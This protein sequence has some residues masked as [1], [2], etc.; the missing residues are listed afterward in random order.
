MKIEGY[1]LKCKEKR[2]MVSPQ[3]EWAANG[4]PATRGTCPVCGTN[5]YKRGHTAAHD[6]LPKPEIQ[7]RPKKKT[8]TKKKASA[9][10]K[11]TATKKAA[12]KNETSVRRTGKLVIV[13]SPA[14]AKTI[15]RYLGKGYT[16]K[17]SV[18]HVRDLLKSR[19]SVDT[20]NEFT[21]EYRVPNDKRKLVKELAEAAAKAQEI[22]LATDPDREGEAIAWHVQES[23]EMDPERTKRVVFHEITKPAILAA[24]E[25]PREIDMDRVD[26]QQARRILDRLVGYKLSPL[27]WRKVH[28]RLSAGRVQSVAVRLVVERERE[29]DNFEPVEYWSLKAELSQQKYQDEA[30]RPFF[31]SKFHKFNGEDPVLNSEADVLPHLDALEKAAWT[32]GNVR[33]GT[34]T[35]KPAAPFTTSTMQQEASRKLNFGTSKTMRVAQQ[36]YEG[37]DLGGED[38]T[39]GLITYMR[40]DSVTVSAEAQ[41]E[42][43]EYVQN[44]YGEKYV[45]AEPPVYKTRS[46]TAQEAHEAV[47][48]TSVMRSPKVVKDHLK[49]DQFRLYKLIWDR[50]VASQMENAVYDT[51][52]ADIWAG[53]ANVAVEKRPYLFRSSGSSLRFAGFLALYEETKSSDE[54]DENGNG[55]GNVPADLTEGE[56][57]DLLRLLPEQ[58]FTQPPPR[59]SEA[60]LVRE[61]EENGIGRPSTYASIISTV[62][63]R[64]YV[65]RED[66]R[67]VPTETGGVVNDL[68]VEYFPD[69]LSVDFTA[70]MEDELDEI[71]EGKQAWVPVIAEFYGPF[72]KDLEKADDAI[73][74]IDLKKEVELVGR[75]CPDCGKPLL[76]REGRYGRFIGCSNFP[77]CRFTEQILNKIGVA[78]PQDGGD[79]V[80]KHTRR[81]RVFYGCANYPACDWTSW[82]RPLAEPA[83]SRC[84]G[85]LVQKNNTTAE[86]TKCGE[87]QAYTQPE[88]VM[89]ES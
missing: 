84:G 59:F 82:K 7:P 78:C 16:V 35:R 6:S 47:R 18:G 31:I 4:S 62:Q 77:Q 45:P 27:L 72:E 51:V 81:G 28:G 42:A 40:T 29:I 60:S 23:A 86:C 30:E 53:D 69:I 75:N 49:R 70:R 74:K 79:L 13:E 67:L 46:K 38:G 68:L 39:T 10:K 52:S 89:I 73:P 66:K 64:G 80:E 33:I 43:R 19:L 83:C 56:Q 25:E 2:D 14:K 54:A 63:A 20:E 41:N 12:S 85:L 76:Y 50:F 15:G 44:Q 22:Y 5:M 32:L 37:V 58:H 8:G 36:L 9:K 17:S 26:A 55:N 61:L 21:P 71:A 57:V 11:K 87:R 48:P 34:R 65:D 1:C 24:F 88:K 3:A